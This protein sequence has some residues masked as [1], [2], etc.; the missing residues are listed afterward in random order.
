MKRLLAAAAGALL[1]PSAALAAYP[2]S[3]AATGDSITRAFNTG[4]IPLADWPTNSWSTGSSETVNSHYGRIVVANPAIA[5][6]SYNDADIGADMGDLNGQAARAVSQRAEYVTIL[7][8]G[9]DLCASSEAGMTPVATFRTQFEAAMQT[10]SSGLPDARIYVVSIPD[11]YRLWEIYWT[12]L[13]ARLVWTTAGICQSMLANPASTAPGDVARRARVRQRNID[14]N[15][16][17]AQVCALYIHCRYDG[18]AA[19]ATDFV[20]SDVSSLDY[21]HPTISGQAK[22]AAVSWSATFDFADS[23]APVS[24]ATVAAGVASVSATDNAGVA[25]IEYRLGGAPWTRYAGPVRLA[26]GSSLT[27]RAV[28]VNG[29]T[30]AARTLTG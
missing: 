10:L 13:A 7:I 20:R 5:G 11:V 9:N 16:Q 21:F 15:T 4:W 25:G 19:F 18:N 17:L 23:L 26:P 6:R 1:V 8:G 22:L 12:S 28:D 24:T 27:Y 29:N 30:E 2:S 3:I 14:Y